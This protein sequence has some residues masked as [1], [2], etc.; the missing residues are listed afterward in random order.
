MERLIFECRVIRF[1]LSARGMGTGFVRGAEM[2][3]LPPPQPHK[4]MAESPTR[5]TAEHLAGISDLL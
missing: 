4:L 5:V 3:P 2:P 1:L